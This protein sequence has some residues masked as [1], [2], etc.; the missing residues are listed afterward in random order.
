MVLTIFFI[1]LPFQFLSWGYF[2]IPITSVTAFTL[3]GFEAMGL[4]LENPFG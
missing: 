3:W 2:V 1:F 4:E